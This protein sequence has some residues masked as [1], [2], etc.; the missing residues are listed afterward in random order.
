MQLYDSALNLRMYLVQENGPTKLVLEDINQRKFKIQ[1]GSTISCSCGGG[2]EEHCVHTLEEP[3]NQKPKQEDKRQTVN[4]MVLDKD[5]PCCVCHENM[6]KEDNLTY[7]Y[8]EQHEFIL[9]PSA[10]KEWEPAF[11]QTQELTL[12]ERS[13]ITNDM[14]TRDIKPEDYLK[15]L[16]A[17]TRANIISLPKYLA[18]A[19]EKNY[20]ATQEYM[21]IAIAYCNFCELKIDDKTKGLSFKNCDHCVHKGCLEDML[22]LKKNHCQ[23]C[24]SVILQGFEKSINIGKIQTNKV[25]LQQKQ[26]ENKKSN[27]LFQIEEEKDQSS[28]LD[29]STVSVNGQGYS[30]YQNGGAH[31]HQFKIR[32]HSKLSNGSKLITVKRQTENGQVKTESFLDFNFKLNGKQIQGGVNSSQIQNQNRDNSINYQRQIS[33]NGQIP[34]QPPYEEEK[35][36]VNLGLAFQDNSNNNSNFNSQNNKNKLRLQRDIEEYKQQSSGNGNYSLLDIGGQ[37]FNTQQ[38]YFTPSQDFLNHQQKQHENTE[39]Q[40][41]LLDRLRDKKVKETLRK[42]DKDMKLNKAKQLQENAP[43]SKYYREQINKQDQNHPQST[44]LQQ[45]ALQITANNGRSSANQNQRTRIN[46]RGNQSNQSNNQGQKRDKQ[47]SIDIEDFRGFLGDLS[48][49]VST[50]NKG[51]FK[52][53]P[54][55]NYS[56]IENSIPNLPDEMLHP[57]FIRMQRL[58]YFKR[59]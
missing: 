44:I 51:R 54:A 10:D 28:P 42:R 14:K 21:R 37:N 45:N 7:C 13:K 55:N 12:E 6:K 34:R 53:N 15:L 24:D 56:L 52:V 50:I 5:E 1:I 8:H 30:N 43:L 58:G 29:Q 20:P 18:L 46:S 23:I 32:N 26:I 25:L 36:P 48:T 40:Q 41:Q 4:R 11:R 17:E 31:Q 22:R 33:I 59:E 16:S 35:V 39:L 3:M 2:R 19:F 9:R 57:D 38:N 47:N 49:D 27:N